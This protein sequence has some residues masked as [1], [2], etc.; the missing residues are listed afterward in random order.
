MN[1]RRILYFCTVLPPFYFHSWQRSA[2]KQ[3]CLISTAWLKWKLLAVC[4][5]T[6]LLRLLSVCMVCCLGFR[7]LLPTIVILWQHLYQCT[8]YKLISKFWLS[9]S[10]EYTSPF[11]LIFIKRPSWWWVLPVNS[12]WAVVEGHSERWGL[13]LFENSSYGI[14]FIVASAR[15]INDN[16][17]QTLP[18]CTQ[19]G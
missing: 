7:M 6:S 17:K 8:I 2:V 1:S 4:L 10:R 19:F 16:S 18:N 11:Q 12:A 5:H 14:F 3:V 15:K 13:I 9:W